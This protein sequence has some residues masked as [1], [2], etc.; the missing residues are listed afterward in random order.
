VTAGAT[1]SDPRQTGA[2]WDWAVAA[3]GRPGAK[4]ALLR[5]QEGAGVD[6]VLTLWRAW[7]WETGRAV[8]PEAEAGA[9][10]LSDAWRQGVVAPLR[11]ARN[12]LRPPP[13]GIGGEAA[14]TLRRRIL[15]AELEA[16]RLQLQALER[17]TTNQAQ[18]ATEEMR[19]DRGSLQDWLWTFPP[20]AP[21]PVVDISALS[22]ALEA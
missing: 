10:A 13:P 18:S 21:A 5:L 19:R 20:L 17:L 12:A 11:A 4:G 14:S 3:Y 8:S 6:V 16:E 9:I 22:A 1:D 15:D 7:L 2:L